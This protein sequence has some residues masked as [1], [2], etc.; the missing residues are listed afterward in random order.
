VGIAQNPEGTFGGSTPLQRLRDRRAH[1]DSIV[2]AGGGDRG[3]DGDGHGGGAAE[4]QVVTG[5][6]R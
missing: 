2:G 3:V 5:A 4:R 1:L 6:A